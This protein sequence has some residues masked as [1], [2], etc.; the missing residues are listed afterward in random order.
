MIL[1]AKTKPKIGEK[2]V[3]K[4]SELLR[5]YKKGKTR[6][7][8]KIIANEAT[9]KGLISTPYSSLYRSSEKQTAQ[10]KNE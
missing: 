10:S 8:Q 3:R 6:L 1:K 4:A 7:E 2:E 9:D 5:E